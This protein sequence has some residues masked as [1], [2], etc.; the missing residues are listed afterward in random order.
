MNDKK[1]MS[2]LFLTQDFPVL[3]QISALLPLVC[4]MAPSRV[5]TLNLPRPQT[6]LLLMRFI[7]EEQTYDLS[8]G[9]KF[10][11]KTAPDNILVIKIL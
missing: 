10:R 1:R 9:I 8:V 5:V 3:K 7:I 11:A 2:I 4:I 6:A